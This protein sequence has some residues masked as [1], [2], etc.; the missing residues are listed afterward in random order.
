MDNVRSADT[1]CQRSSLDHYL[2]LLSRQL[3]ATCRH[4]S[5]ER[6][7][8]MTTQI[9]EWGPSARRSPLS[10]RPYGSFMTQLVAATAAFL[11]LVSPALATMNILAHEYQ[12]KFDQTL[13]LGQCPMREQAYQMEN[14][15]IFSKTICPYTFPGKTRHVKR[16]H[17]FSRNVIINRPQ[18][19]ISVLGLCGGEAASYLGILNS[20]D[21]AG[22]RLASNLTFG[23]K[24]VVRAYYSYFINGVDVL[25]HGPNVP[26]SVQKMVDR[27]ID[28]GDRYYLQSVSY[29]ALEII[30][31]Q[32]RFMSVQEAERARE[33]DMSGKSPR[34]TEYMK[35]IRTTVGTPKHVMVTSMS[36]TH[37][38]SFD[39]EDFW[40]LKTTPEMWDR[41]VRHVY[42]IESN[43][44]QTK[45]GI[46]NGH[47]KQQFKYHFSPFLQEEAARYRLTNPREWENI[48][49]IEVRL[50][51][52]I[53]MAKKITKKC[54]RNRSILCKRVRQHRKNLLAL[55][56]EIH[57]K[58][59]EWVKIPAEEKTSFI[60]KYRI[61]VA[62]SSRLTKN[63][64]RE[65]L[66]LLGG[67]DIENED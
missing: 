17:N 38:K 12:R 47:I 29:G 40:P 46:S 54:R 57:K 31:V 39:Y 26:A 56:R 59:A 33:I 23:S 62:T 66:R 13:T 53:T 8:P 1:D 27:N 35:L 48:S 51:G 19:I 61:K 34:M 44:E 6:I 14:Q 50:R 11:F 16:E 36:S 65:A 43:M 60:R 7:N 28:L 64:T 42:L 58:R 9:S 5:G 63:L 15:T 45:I 2:Q 4:C 10:S 24:T 21:C 67:I 20:G 25:D 18:D 49:M 32:F 52:D 55:K 3:T 30:L 41:A 37:P 22:I